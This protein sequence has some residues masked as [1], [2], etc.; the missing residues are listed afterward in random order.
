M[1]RSHERSALRAHGL[2]CARGDRTVFS[3]LA[4]ELANGG[5]LR[6]G[7]PNGSGKTSLLRMVCGLLE[8]AAGTIDWNGAPA[9]ALG[10]DYHR[11]LAYVGHLNGAKDELDVFEN[12]A[13]A[14]RSAGLPATPDDVTAAL[15]E[16]SLD[17]LAGLQCKFLS[18]GQKRRLALARL[19][20][21]MSR[22]LWVLD[23]PFVA[24]DVAGI[25]VV[26]LMIEEHLRGG[27]LVVL[28]THQEIEIAS[29]SAQRIELSA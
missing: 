21:C 6:I 16:Y 3:G 19:R 7:G 18:Q 24:I 20:L 8:P 9:R 28:T 29:A 25:E 1:S 17:R 13:H 12:L 27:G 14:A 26:R 11:D 10:E 15:R 23:E 4:F 22:A 2:A 5:L